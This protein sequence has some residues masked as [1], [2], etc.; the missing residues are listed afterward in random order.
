MNAGKAAGK[1]AMAVIPSKRRATPKHVRTYAVYIYRAMKAVV[2]DASVTKNS[3]AVLNS[4]CVDLAKRIIIDAAELTKYSKRSTIGARDIETATRL[5]MPGELGMHAMANGSR[6]TLEFVSVPDRTERGEGHNKKKVSRSEKAGL[7]FP[8]GRISSYMR[9]GGFSKMIG[10]TAPVY[11]AA[12]MEY[13]IQEI[14]EVAWECVKKEK[15]ARI[16]P[17]HISMSIKNDDELNQLFK[18]ALI[19][20]GGVLPHIHPFLLP[21]NAGRKKRKNE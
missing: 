2:E 5:I 6:A 19:S 9:T 14:I 12:V 16:T 1:A 11:L 4:L 18:T 17:K 13:V 20:G 21:K 8:V 3:M 7:V 10:A 15:K